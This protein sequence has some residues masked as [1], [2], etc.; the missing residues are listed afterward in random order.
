MTLFPAILLT[1]WQ[2][3]NRK[4]CAAQIAAA[5]ALA[6]AI[7]ALWIVP[8]QYRAPGYLSALLHN[9]FA[10]LRNP[11]NP[12]IGIPRYLNLLLWYAWPAL[13]MAAWALWS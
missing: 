9:E 3:D 11:A 5:I 1:I 8:L 12:L 13:P 2:A 6:A 10:P 4:R 7:V